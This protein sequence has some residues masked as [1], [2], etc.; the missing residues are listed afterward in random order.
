MDDGLN[1]S[2]NADASV[3]APTHVS[4]DA[5]APSILLGRASRWAYFLEMIWR[6]GGLM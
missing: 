1:I 4:T 6:S 3:V 5:V 2:V